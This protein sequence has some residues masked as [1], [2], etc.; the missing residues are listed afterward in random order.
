MQRTL[1]TSSYP[2]VISG[3]NITM[4]IKN[5]LTHSAFTKM[6]LTESQLIVTSVQTLSKSPKI[7]FRA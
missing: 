2:S 3:N 5:C 6:L 1:Y 7:I 4:E